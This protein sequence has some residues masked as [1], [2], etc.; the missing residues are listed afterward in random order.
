[1][2]GEKRT[3]AATYRAADL[4]GKAPAVEVSGYNVVAE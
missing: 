3:V 4:G 2:P 1:M